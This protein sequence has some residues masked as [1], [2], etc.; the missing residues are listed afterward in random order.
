MTLKTWNW[1]QDD[2]PHFSYD[3]KKLDPLEDEYIKESGISIGVM[4]HLSKKDLDEFRIEM[5]CDEAL[6]TSEIE[7]EFLDRDSL[8][9]EKRRQNKP[10]H[11]R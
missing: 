9:L 4:R 7:G 8:H 11:P 1:Q 5:I 10:S 2:W 3:K 6:K